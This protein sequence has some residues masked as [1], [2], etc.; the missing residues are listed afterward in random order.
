MDPVN[1][2][3]KKNELKQKDYGCMIIDVK[4]KLLKHALRTSKYKLADPGPYRKARKRTKPEQAMKIMLEE[5]CIEFEEEFSVPFANTFKV[6]DFR[7]G[8][9]LLIEVDGDF[10]H[11]RVEAVKR[12]HTMHIKN[13]QNDIIKNWIAKERGYKLFRFWETDIM[14]NKDMVIERLKKIIM[15]ND[16]GRIQEH[17]TD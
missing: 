15:E 9:N 14:K 17:K 1:Y 3:E 10:V 6:Y 12:F 7:I 11:G 16:I 2:T 4:K 5:L 8:R 13:K